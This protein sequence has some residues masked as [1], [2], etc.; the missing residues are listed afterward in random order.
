[1]VCF[2]AL[3]AACITT[4]FKK[5]LVRERAAFDLECDKVKVREL[6]NSTFGATGCGK[7]ETYLVKCTGGKAR[8]D[9][10][11]AVKN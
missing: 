1:M 6:G 8:T 9:L 5:E 2:V 11:N 7:R 3:C 4:G 10:C